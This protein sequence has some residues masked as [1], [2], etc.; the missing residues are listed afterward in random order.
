MRFLASWREKGDERMTNTFIST[1]RLRRRFFF[2]S[3]VDEMQE[4]SGE[5]DCWWWWWWRLGG[6][7]ICLLHITLKA[8]FASFPPQETLPPLTVN[9][10]FPLRRNPTHRRSC[11]SSRVR[12]R[13]RRH[14]GRISP[15]VQPVRPSSPSFWFEL[16]VKQ[17][18]AAP[19]VS[20]GFDTF[21]TYF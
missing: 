19:V 2:R 7:V 18:A 11:S 6:G 1:E 10:M 21:G 13:S 12:A 16:N 5:R 20:G 3:A 4:S 8:H 17:L 14:A 15:P 9:C